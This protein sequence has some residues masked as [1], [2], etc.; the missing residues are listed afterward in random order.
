VDERSQSSW[1]GRNWFWAV[2]VGCL[3][4]L[5]ICGGCV[6][7]VLVTV[8]GAIRVSDP[9]R[10][11]VAAATASPEVKAELGEPLEVGFWTNGNIQINNGSGT[12]K[13]T[14]P[15]KGPKKSGTITVD[16]TKDAGTWEYSTLE[17]VPEEGGK[18]I[19]LRPKE[20]KE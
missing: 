10:E 13:I 11:A 18:P 17:V 4:P 7:A 9:Y 3:S 15:I 5:L 16:A 20:S 14:I 6:A 2:P 12:A 1:W 8:T 19:D